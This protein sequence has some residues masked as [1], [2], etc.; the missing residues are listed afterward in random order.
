MESCCCVD[1]DGHWGFYRDEIRI[2]RKEHKCTECNC[3]INPGEEYEYQ[4]G[5]F[6]GALQHHKTC[7]FCLAIRRDFFKCGW[8]FGM[9]RE[10]F[11]ECH[12]WDYVTMEGSDD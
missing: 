9:L 8:V 11:S 5:R 7:W 10:D 4:V 2:A 12:G 6:D 3:T 1:W